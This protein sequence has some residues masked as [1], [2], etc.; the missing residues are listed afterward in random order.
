MIS[1]YPFASRREIL[2]RNNST[3]D[4][5]DIVAPAPFEGFR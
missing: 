5:S 3:D 1:T 2:S 4:D